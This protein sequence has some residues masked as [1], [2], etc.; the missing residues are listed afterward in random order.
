MKQMRAITVVLA[1]LVV[2]ATVSG[3]VRATPSTA[4]GMFVGE[5]ATFDPFTVNRHSGADGG[6]SFPWEVVVEAMRG[7][8][9]ATQTI[10]FAPGAQSGWHSHPGPV[11]ISVSVGT[12]TFYEADC[13]A[14]VRM[15]GEGFLDTGSHP[16]LAR[17][18]SNATA[19]N[20]VTYFAPPHT[21]KSQL[22][23]DE[24]QPLNC[25]L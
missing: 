21:S 7:V 20:V 25:P 15:A 3:L 23:H 22:R 12:M 13:T 11:F 5:P 16:H 17:N 1:T 2:V 18:E 6:S 9:I 24:L 19:I 10:T 8:T 14:T 4:M